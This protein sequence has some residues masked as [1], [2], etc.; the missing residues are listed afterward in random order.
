M[1]C[2]WT[3]FSSASYP[4]SSVAPITRRLPF[5]SCKPA[6]RPRCELT[7]TCHLPA[8]D[9]RKFSSSRCCRASDMP[10]GRSVFRNGV[11]SLRI[12]VP[13]QQAGRKPEDRLWFLPE[14]SRCTRQ[15]LS[16]AAQSI[17]HPRTYTRKSRARRTVEHQVH[18]HRM[19][20]PWWLRCRACTRMA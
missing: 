2:V 13:W 19:R 8:T 10:F 14:A 18:R 7:A 9:Q 11:P 4:I 1:S 5:A 15:R 17:G 3:G 20:K 16:L 12:T 6:R